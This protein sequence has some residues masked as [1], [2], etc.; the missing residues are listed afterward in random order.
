MKA[1]L[2]L[3]LILLGL[4][5]VS[6][7]QAANLFAGQDRAATVCAQCHGIKKP[8][9]QAPFPSLAGRDAAYLKEA[10]KQYRS[11]KRVSDLMN[12][13]AGSLRDSDI[14]DLAAYYSKLKP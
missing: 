14:D 10:L 2:Y 13:I 4:T 5:A 11:K 9:A 7:T 3:P 6:T 12:A 8:N 1:A